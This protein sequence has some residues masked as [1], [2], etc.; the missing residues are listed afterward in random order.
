MK[1]DL[2]SNAGT[3]LRVLIAEDHAYMR[4]VL[5]ALLFSLGVEVV[6]E[7]HDGRSAVR[8]ADQLAPDLVIMD[9]SMPDIEGPEATRLLLLDHPDVPVIALSAHSEPEWVE[10]ALTAGAHGYV[11]KDVAYEDLATAIHTVLEGGHF[12][13]RQIHGSVGLLKAHLA[14]A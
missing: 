14:R 11:L 7:A 3:P 5:T 13:S 2:T 8:L 12:V 6:G 10:A 9:M 4:E 1:Q